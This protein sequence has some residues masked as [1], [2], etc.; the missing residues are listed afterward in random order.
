MLKEEEEGFGKEE[1]WDN[2]GTTVME[3]R[4]CGV[5]V[6]TTGYPEIM[7]DAPKPTFS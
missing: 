1:S 2:L 5:G 7:S 4:L 3:L 6:E